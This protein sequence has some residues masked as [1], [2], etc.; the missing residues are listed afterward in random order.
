MFVDDFYVKFGT[1]SLM[2]YISGFSDFLKFFPFGQFLSSYW[3]YRVIFGTCE[4]FV[5]K[6]QTLYFIPFFPKFSFCAVVS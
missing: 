5:L 6:F 3:S 4:E 1:G 2:T